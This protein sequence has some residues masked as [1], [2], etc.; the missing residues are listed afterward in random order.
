LLFAQIQ[1]N[2]SDILLFRLEKLTEF[3]LVQYHQQR[4][5]GLERV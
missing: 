5:L 4:A 1:V 2:G 3:L